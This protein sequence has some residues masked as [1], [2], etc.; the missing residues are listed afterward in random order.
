MQFGLNTPFTQLENLLIDEVDM[1]TRK[2]SSSFT[3]H[4]CYWSQAGVPLFT[5]TNAVES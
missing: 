2:I 1:I 5:Y 3:L 4:L